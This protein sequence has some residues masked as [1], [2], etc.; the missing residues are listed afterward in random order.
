MATLVLGSDSGDQK[1][2]VE[3]IAAAKTEEPDC[4]TKT[5]NYIEGL[6]KSNNR[7][8]I[9][10]E[11]TD[12]ILQYINIDN[13]IQEKQTIQ[14][15]MVEDIEQYFP[16]FMETN[17]R[18]N[19][20]NC[21][22]TDIKDVLE[23]PLNQEITYFLQQKPQISVEEDGRYTKYPVLAW[24]L[25]KKY[26]HKSR[27]T[28]EPQNI[29]NFYTFIQEPN[30]DRIDYINTIDDLITYIRNEKWNIDNQQSLEPAPGS[31]ESMPK[32]KDLRSTSV[33]NLKD[34]EGWTKDDWGKKPPGKP[35]T[36][37]VG[38]APNLFRKED[39]K[40]LPKLEIPQARG[41]VK[42]VIKKS[43]TSTPERYAGSHLFTCDICRKE[44]I[45]N[46]KPMS[47]QALA[48][49]IKNKHAYHSPPKKKSLKFNSSQ[50]LK[51][52]S[53]L[54][55]MNTGDTN[56]SYPSSSSLGVR[57]RSPSFSPSIS[58]SMSREPSSD[59]LTLDRANSKELLEPK[60][61]QRKSKNK[62]IGK[63]IGKKKQRLRSH[64]SG[65][66]DEEPIQQS[67]SGLQVKRSTSYESTFGNDRKVSP[68]S[69]NDTGNVFDPL[70]DTMDLRTNERLRP[71][72]PMFVEDVDPE[73]YTKLFLEK[74]ERSKKK[75][76]KSKSRRRRKKRTK[77]KSR[78]KKRN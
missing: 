39:F 35:P 37:T 18:L 11:I 65:D 72:T 78:R 6:G 77:K 74:E 38:P 59:F 21:L 32:L 54:K 2:E 31:I 43:E 16:I 7:M 13:L 29:I 61:I 25:F 64:S 52:D 14:N 46:L 15:L 19:R 28:Y 50:D 58:P 49:H 33:A 22:R 12:M 5:Y 30:N 70:Y 76:G 67:P 56:V 8:H 60:T 4:I 63:K 17:E 44:G 45:N 75:G 9:W 23:Q 10:N 40:G 71:P 51:E 34:V 26:Y 55:K 42:N 48:D 47:R 41:W 24:Y 68:K 3:L 53:E 27:S 73:E 36:P 66:L 1:E 20:I 69:N 62:K 57:N